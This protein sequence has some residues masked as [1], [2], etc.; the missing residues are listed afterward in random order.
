M[1]QF[2]ANKKIVVPVDFSD[3]AGEALDEALQMSDPSTRVIAL[4][5]GLPLHVIAVDPGVLVDL[6]SDLER[7]DALTQRLQGAYGS[8]KDERLEFQVRIGDPGTEIVDF[9]T[10]SQADLVVMSSHGRTGLGRLLLGSV[11]ERVV[12]L[13]ECPVMV[14]RK[15]KNESP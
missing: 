4:H 8:K 11:A 1:S 13:A 14:I 6:G 7:C 15:P 12:R 2:F 10:S 5:V 3:A 9:A